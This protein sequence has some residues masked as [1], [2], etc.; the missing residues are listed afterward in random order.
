MLFGY[1]EINSSDFPVIMVKP[2]QNRPGNQR[3]FS[4]RCF[5][6]FF[7]YYRSLPPDTLMGPAWVVVLNYVFTKQ[8]SKMLFI[9]RNYMV[10]QLAMEYAD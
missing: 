2:T 9:E 4:N 1:R 6:R 10:E 5:I 8:I 3:S 7:G